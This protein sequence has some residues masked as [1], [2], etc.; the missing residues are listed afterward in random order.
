MKNNEFS[1]DTENTFNNPLLQDLLNQGLCTKEELSTL[2]QQAINILKKT[3][4]IDQYTYSGVSK[5]GIRLVD[6]LE[7]CRNYIHDKSI[8]NIDRLNIV[9]DYKI[10]NAYKGWTNV[11]GVKENLT[12]DQL[13]NLDNESISRLTSDSAIAAYKGWTNVYGVKEN[14]TFDQLVDRRIDARDYISAGA[15]AAYK[16]GA[17]FSDLFKLYEDRQIEL[18]NILKQYQKFKKDKLSL[19]KDELSSNDNKLESLT[20][21]S[22]YAYE[23]GATFQQLSKLYSEDIK[24]FRALTLYCQVCSVTN[25][26]SMIA[27]FSEL[28][29]L[30]SEDLSKFETLIYDADSL[31]KVGIKPQ[32]LKV[33][34][35][36][37]IIALASYDVIELCGGSEKFDISRFN[38]LKSF[39]TEKITELAQAADKYKVSYDVL[40]QLYESD[41]E[42]FTLLVSKDAANIYRNSYLPNDET[43][44]SMQKLDIPT[45]KAQ[46]CISQTPHTSIDKKDLCSLYNPNSSSYMNSEKL[47][48]F[49]MNANGQLHDERTFIAN[50]SAALSYISVM[51]G[52]EQTIAYKPSLEQGAVGELVINSADKSLDQPLIVGTTKDLLRAIHTD[53]A[54]QLKLS[55]KKDPLLQKDSEKEI[56][57]VE[58]LSNE[59]VLLNDKTKDEIKNSSLPSWIKECLSS[60]IQFLVK[61]VQ[62]VTCRTQS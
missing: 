36:P 59:K 39:D 29:E 45:I 23:A 11:H 61:I 55:Q 60:I 57:F 3:R 16:G 15:M 14:L 4:I 44:I 8:L 50:L 26:K 53:I 46:I 38:E 40:K 9:T 7:N 31:Y 20:I 48:R 47:T 5:Y 51:S 12:F 21:M 18:E 42:K 19:K 49:M 1:Q 28:L 27:S 13:K 22:K 62:T 35:A 37:K 56:S 30:C 34:D 43:F 58:K 54:E 10:T 41:H 24:K 17:K 6:V 52:H 2:D 25:R 32:E 33:F